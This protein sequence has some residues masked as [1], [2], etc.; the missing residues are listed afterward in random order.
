MFLALVTAVG[1]GSDADARSW[2]SSPQDLAR[3]YL[4]IQDQRAENE[5][6]LVV[7]LAP[8]LIPNDPE[9][10]AARDSLGRYGVI[11]V[12]HARMN[13]LGEFSF[14]AANDVK[15]RISGG[16][17]KRALSRDSIPPVALAGVEAVRSIFEKALGPMGN[18]THWHVFD[19]SSLDSCDNGQLAVLFAGEKYTYDTP[20]PGC[21]GSQLGSLTPT[22]Q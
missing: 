5:I 20:I 9:S 17:A 12:I 18:G 16:A 3:E 2:R 21:Q 4:I 19:T 13:D 6:V 1:F 11:G 22:R 7:W 10:R 15:I 14:L 8:A